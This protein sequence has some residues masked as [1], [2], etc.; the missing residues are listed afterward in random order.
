MGGE[1]LWEAELGEG[2]LMDS[3]DPG[4]ITARHR[5]FPCV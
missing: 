1:L 5:A 3:I 4:S 2:K